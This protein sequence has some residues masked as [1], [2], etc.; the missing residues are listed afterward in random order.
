MTVRTPGAATAPTEARR[1]GDPA[2]VVRALDLLAGRRL[3]VL[4]GAGLSTDS[5]IPDVMSLRVAPDVLRGNSR[6]V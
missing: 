1:S 5:G 3:V 6:R 4:S 2:D